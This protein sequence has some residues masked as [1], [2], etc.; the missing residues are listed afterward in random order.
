MR[1]SC[2]SRGKARS[3]AADGSQHPI[4]SEAANGKTDDPFFALFQAMIPHSE[5]FCNN[6]YFLSANLLT[7]KTQ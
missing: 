2:G 7:K 1:S 5:F 3:S 6:Y 4:L